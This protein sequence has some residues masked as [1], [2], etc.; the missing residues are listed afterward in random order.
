MTPT[1]SATMAAAGGRRGDRVLFIGGNWF[2]NQRE[3]GGGQDRVYGCISL[4]S[5]A[6]T[7]ICKRRKEGG[8]D[9]V[10]F[11]FWAFGVRMER[12][13]SIHYLLRPPAVPTVIL[14]P[15][16]PPLPEPRAALLPRFLRRA[17][18]FP[19]RVRRRKGDRRLLHAGA[20]GGDKGGSQN[21]RC[22]C[23]SGTR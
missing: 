10:H 2:R 20:A 4:H 19:S 6:A 5:I 21:R 22:A 9:R 23:A 1:P 7:T 15:G 18:P 12:A 11:P 17:Q 13:S 14:P 16:P 3:K 8:G